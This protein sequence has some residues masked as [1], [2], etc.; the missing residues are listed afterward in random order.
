MRATKRKRRTKNFFG[1][2]TG[3]MKKGLS[4]ANGRKVQRDTEVTSKATET[5]MKKTVAVNENQASERR[6]KRFIR[7][8]EFPQKDQVIDFAKR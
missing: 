7:F 5:R 3:K 6:K 8:K 1:G 4:N 2:E